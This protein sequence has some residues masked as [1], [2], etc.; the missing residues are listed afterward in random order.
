MANEPHILNST[1]T[2]VDDVLENDLKNLKDE[3][4]FSF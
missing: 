1:I 3:K 4:Y 2:Y